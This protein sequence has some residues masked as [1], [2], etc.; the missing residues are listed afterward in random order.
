MEQ[1]ECSFLTPLDGDSETGNYQCPGCARVFQ[2]V[3]YMRMHCQFM[4][5][6]LEEGSQ[7]ATERSTLP[8]GEQRSTRRER[9]PLLSSILSRKAD[10]TDEYVASVSTE[11]LQIH[12]RRLHLDQTE[13]RFWWDRR[14]RLRAIENSRV[15]RNRQ[16]ELL[17][18]MRQQ[19]EE[20]SRLRQQLLWQ[21]QQQ[22]Q[23]MVIHEKVE[24][25][26]GHGV[27]EMGSLQEPGIVLRP[28]GQAVGPVH[29]SDSVSGALLNMQTLAPRDDMVVAVQQFETCYQMSA[30]NRLVR[31]GE[32]SF[33][34]QNPTLTQDL[35]I[36]APSDACLI[37][38]RYW[39][40]MEFSASRLGDTT[41]WALASI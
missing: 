1:F 2:Y 31:I 10:F 35:L 17:S 24:E 18:R 7:R 28:W 19:A 30:G 32:S 41:G 12:M 39:T 21:C 38:V 23:R 25:L 14:R 16:A 13:V 4:H 20:E 29:L 8:R 27:E 15:R 26:A 37:P 22:Q 33:M 11:S 34:I 9:C 36:G 5:P 40:V 3:G 6:E